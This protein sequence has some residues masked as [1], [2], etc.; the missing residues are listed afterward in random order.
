VGRFGGDG[1]GV[2]VSPI[3]MPRVV[4]RYT[5][6][7]LY[8]T[9]TSRYVSLDDVA[10]FVRAGEEVQVLDNVSGDD[11]TSV[12]LAQIILEDERR[13][14][15][16]VSIPLLEDL[17]RGGGDAIVDATRQATE[18]IDDF[19]SKAEQRVNDLVAEGV[20]RR[21]AFMG[22]I[23][24]SRTRLDNLQKQIDDG[25]RDSIDR[26]RDATGIGAELEKLEAGLREVEGRIRSL[27][28]QEEA[29]EQ[30]KEAADSRPENA[31]GPEEAS[32]KAEPENAEAGK[33]DP[34]HAESAS[35]E[36]PTN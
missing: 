29:A 17:V 13:K 30:A 31:A 23:D 10:V 18:V 28:L 16:F 20:S 34:G 12:T 4:K 27:L 1:W 5:N 11:L 26:F 21:D 33:A 7:K 19:R 6:R 35:T 36:P 25:V 14:K 22:V 9:A 3:V 2:V 32:L 15:S 24:S 8:D